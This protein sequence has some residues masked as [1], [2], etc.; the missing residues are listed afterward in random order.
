MSATNPENAKSIEDA[1]QRLKSSAE[2][3]GYHLNP[4][5]NFTIDLVKGLLTN[6]DRYGYSAC[7]CRLASGV[8]SEDMDIICPCDYRDPDLEEYGMCYCGLYV[9]QDVVAGKKSIAEGN[10]EIKLRGQADNQQVKIE[11]ALIQVTELVGK[12]KGQLK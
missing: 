11:Q 7:P 9:S 10:V 3:A 8:Q 4:D 5:K 1:Y 6:K 2:S 12:L